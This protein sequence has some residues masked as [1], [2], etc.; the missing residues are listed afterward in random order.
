MNC[1]IWAITRYNV[2][3]VKRKLLKLAVMVSECVRH[4]RNDT[5]NS[6]TPET[7]TG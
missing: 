5:P 7:G 1:R 2:G 6:V 3:L 4:A